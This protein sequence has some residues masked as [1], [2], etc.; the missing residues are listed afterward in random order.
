[1]ADGVLLPLQA[2]IPYSGKTPNIDLWGGDND[3]WQ[4][5][6]YQISDIEMLQGTMTSN[7]PIDMVHWP[8]DGSDPVHLLAWWESC[9]QLLVHF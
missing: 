8:V 3:D 1:M 7:V 6:I 9:L 5:Y 4:D 2:G